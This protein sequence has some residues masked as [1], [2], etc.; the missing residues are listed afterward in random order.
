MD[1]S[2]PPATI[3]W[4]STLDL[5]YCAKCTMQGVS[6]G[7]CPRCGIHL[8]MPA[9]S[10]YKLEN[11]GVTTCSQWGNGPLSRDTA[12]CSM[13][14]AT[15]MEDPNPKQT[16][17]WLMP[18]IIAM[19][20]CVI[21]TAVF[22]PI[23]FRSSKD[24]SMRELKA[25]EKVAQDRLDRIAAAKQQIA[26]AKQQREVD[27]LRQLDAQQAEIDAL[28]QKNNQTDSTG[29]ESNIEFNG[30]SSDVGA[31]SNGNFDS[32]SAE[33]MAA[34]A[35]DRDDYELRRE[36]DRQALERQREEYARQRDQ[37]RREDE[38]RRADHERILE[39]EKRDDDRRREREDE[40][41]R[42]NDEIQ[43]RRETERN[44]TV[45][46]RCRLC[47]RQEAGGTVGNQ[48][49]PD[50]SG[51]PSGTTHSWSKEWL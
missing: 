51:C 3:L 49:V 31:G 44:K 35:R 22:I 11:R 43:R 19:A 12:S 45:Y 18:S 34:R 23:A 40:M 29:A 24:S 36:Q 5:W 28:K 7:S 10:A 13:C 20:A 47:K 6:E 26:L 4:N 1:S 41:R 42:F 2:R 21:G 48:R 8:K 14:R 17:T 46:F 33:D 39:N 15:L 37:D 16:N 32:N 30:F 38:R 50:D 25:M 9:K 27:M